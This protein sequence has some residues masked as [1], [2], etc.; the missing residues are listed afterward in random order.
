MGTKP[1][2]KP[3]AANLAWVRRKSWP[4][5][6]LHSVESL[7]L[8]DLFCGCGGLSL[9]VWE[10]ARVAGLQLDVR[11]AVDMAREPLAVY[12]GNFDCPEDTAIQAPVESVFDGEL[13][14]PITSVE[15]AWRKRLGNVDL[16]VAGP[17]CQGHSDLNN[18]TRRDDPRNQ[19][20]LRVVRGAE[21]LKPNVV[22]VENVRA[23]LLDAS[24]VV[25]TAVDTLGELGYVVSQDTV[26]MSKIGVPQ[27][28]NRHILV[29][30]R[31]P[32][33]ELNAWVASL[34]RQT[35]TT[36]RYIEGLEDEPEQKDDA[37]YQPSQ[38]TPDNRRRVR[39]LFKQ[40]VHDLPNR[41][42]PPCHRDKDHGYVSMYG[43]MHWDKPAQTIT[44][45]FGS[46]GQG[47]FVHPTRPRTL[48]AHEAARLQGFPDFYD[49]S[50]AKGVTAL[51]EMIGN[52]VPPQL[53]ALLVARLLEDGHL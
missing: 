22:I 30:S 46:M 39:F 36:G 50:C 49:F 11:L 42:R 45:G 48:T 4:N 52:A 37:F 35:P 51:R 32:G 10:A 19:L 23:V 43:R 44:S 27:V 34:K 26:L 12:R 14:E 24:C 20:Y 2:R 40:D 15:R 47:R 6:H 13:G 9:G 38:M 3:P 28:R 41:L 29:A 8:V 16:L 1:Q 17:P 31:T 21:I 7:S 53:T 33:F 5:G 18:S 25:D